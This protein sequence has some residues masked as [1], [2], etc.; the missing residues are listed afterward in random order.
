M[1]SKTIFI[2]GCSSGIG[3]AAARL[4][5]SKGWNVVATLRN[6][7]AAPSELSSL[8]PA[9]RLLITKCDVIDPKTIEAA[10]GETIKA[11][12]NVDWIVNNAGWGQIGIF[13]AVT[14]E[15]AMEQFNVNFVG[16][17]MLSSTVSRNSSDPVS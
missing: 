8:Q 14:R 15:K 10:V 1:S 17:S 7:T 12:G 16:S 11:F 5:H 3:L 6:P 2:T 9:S 4:F 13:E